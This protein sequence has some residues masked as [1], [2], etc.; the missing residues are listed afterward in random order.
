MRGEML[1]RTEGLKVLVDDVLIDF[2]CDVP[3]E[4]G[5]F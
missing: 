5:L 4:Y 1:R 2:L 3:D